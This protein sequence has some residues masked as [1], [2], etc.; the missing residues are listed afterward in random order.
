MIFLIN[1]R[2]KAD[3]EK[4]T[5]TDQSKSQTHHL[6]NRLISV[7]LLLINA[8]GEIVKREQMIDEVW[9]NYPGGDEGLNQAI[10]HLRKYLDDN[11]KELIKTIPKKGYV[12]N[13][14]I[15]EEKS[16]IK[17]TKTL[18][19]EVNRLFILLILAGII[20]VSFLIY[21]NTQAVKNHFSKEIFL[22]NEEARSRLDSIHQAETLKKYENKKD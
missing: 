22:K 17:E 21:Q 19:W 4:N 12:L 15:E 11:T 5:I 13:A 20:V 6:E 16:E 7:L 9:K 2:F 8:K 14:T 10:S 1:N 3:F 18:R